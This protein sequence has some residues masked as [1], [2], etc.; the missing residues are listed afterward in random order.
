MK[1]PECKSTEVASADWLQNISGKLVRFRKC[2]KCG[3][4]WSCPDEPKP[5]VRG[6][7]PTV[8]AVPAE[9]AAK[10]LPDLRAVPVPAVEPAPVP[11]PAPKPA[12]VKKARK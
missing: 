7:E 4:G 6:V 9:I 10:P 2:R 3:Y 8:P 12:P 1:C 11:A 5:E